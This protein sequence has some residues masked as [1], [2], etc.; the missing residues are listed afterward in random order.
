M[1]HTTVRLVDY[2]HT[3]D[4]ERSTN[5]GSGMWG[6]SGTSQDSFRGIALVVWALAF[7]VWALALVVWALDET[8]LIRRRARLLWACRHLGPRLGSRGAHP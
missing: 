7:V 6:T 3:L 5:T 4:L 1:D 8:E 2:T